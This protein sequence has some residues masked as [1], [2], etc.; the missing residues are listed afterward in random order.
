MARQLKPYKVD[1][2]RSPNGYTKAPV[3]F[4]RNSK[5]FFIEAVPGDTD[6]RVWS[7]TLD[8]VKRRGT[9]ALADAQKYEWTPLIV[10][11]VSEHWKRDPESRDAS[12]V[13]SFRRFERSPHPVRGDGFVERPHSLDVTD[14]KGRVENRDIEPCSVSGKIGP[15]IAKD[16]DALLPYSQEVW[17]GLVAIQDTIND[18]RVRL[19]QLLKRKDAGRVLMLGARSNHAAA[20]RGVRLLSSAGDE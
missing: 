12:L 3:M 11:S 5:R 14:A 9:A 1:E 18:A 19:E 4:D 7:D 16:D 13:F 8:D 17:D 15:A 20:L 2:I 10:I 6:S